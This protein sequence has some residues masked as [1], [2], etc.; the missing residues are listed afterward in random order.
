[1][2]STATNALALTKLPPAARECYKFPN[3]SIATPLMSVRK[4]D[5]ANLRTTFE[6][7][8]VTV[9]N[10]TGAVI[11]HGLADPHTALY[12]VHTSDKHP[13][14]LP[15]TTSTQP[16]SIHTT[17]T[18]ANAYNIKAVPALINYYHA[19]MGSPHIASWIK[20]IHLGYFTG[21]PGLTVNRV[22]CYCT[23]KP[24]TTY[25]YQKLI[26]KNIQ[27]TKPKPKPQSKFH[28]VS[29]HII[30]AADLRNLIATDLPRQY[31]ITSARGHK[32]LF[33]TYDQDSNFINAIPIHSRK[34][35]E[36]IRA[37]K[38][39]YNKLSDHGLTARLLKLNN[40]VSKDLIKVITDTG[41]KYQLVSPGDHRPNPAER[42]IQAFK[43]HFIA[44][45]SGTDRTFPQDCWDLLVPL[46]LVSTSCAHHESTQPF[47]LTPR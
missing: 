7:D 38:E 20:Q 36:L 13:I 22:Q 46:A 42:A 8:R 19:T 21:W 17:H 28:D 39:C 6:N 43:S 23:K 32:Y 25:G 18:A 27:S 33:L 41:L 9:T 24:Q 15:G 2:T 26:K 30:E 16:S 3:K 35:P 11:L 12:M 29:T 14:P 47:Q 45:R 31:P 10:K 37:F 34:T 40:E 1:M 5:K 44:T 4:L